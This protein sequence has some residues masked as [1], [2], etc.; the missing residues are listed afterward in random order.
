MW[1]A[2]DLG[3]GAFDVIDFDGFAA[4]VGVGVHGA[5]FGG[6]VRL[7]DLPLFRI[8]GRRDFERQDHADVTVRR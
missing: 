1:I 5:P 4:R 7:G 6:V 8:G 3:S 2:V